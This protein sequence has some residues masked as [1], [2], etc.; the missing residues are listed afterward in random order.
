[1]QVWRFNEP[2]R[3]VMPE[4]RKLAPATDFHSTSMLVE[5]DKS[6]AYVAGLVCVGSEWESSRRGYDYNRES[7]PNALNIRVDGP[8]RLTI[9][10]GGYLFVV[11]SEGVMSRP[12]IVSSMEFIG[13]DACITK[14]GLAALSGGIVPPR[15]E[16][17][18]EYVDFEFSAYLNV[19]V[20]IVNT[21][22]AARHGGTLILVNDE[23]SVRGR[24]RPKFSMAGGELGLR[25]V[26][27]MN[28]RNLVT[29]AW[30]RANGAETAAQAK[31]YVE[32]REALRDLGRTAS[33]VGRLA[34]VDGAVVMTADF[35][36]IGFGAEILLDGLP[37]VHVWELREPEDL[38]RRKRLRRLDSEQY[39]MRHRSAMRLCGNVRGVAALVVSQDG[40]VNSVF[41]YEGKLYFRRNLNAVNTVMVGA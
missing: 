19:I 14:P 17:T 37:D 36:V 11:L 10:Q 22:D 9:F 2:R 38:W 6:N 31:S 1:M 24:I 29:D 32:Y 34:A 40:G 5:Y 8:G 23:E 33:F 4:L 20:S 30:Y 27:F 3:L 26:Q 21:I 7:P 15:R 25:F 35:R 41:D 12:P 16:P 18:R 39:G 28:K 13:I